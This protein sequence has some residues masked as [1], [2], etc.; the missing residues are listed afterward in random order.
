MDEEDLLLEKTVRLYKAKD[1]VNDYESCES[2]EWLQRN[3]AKTYMYT[4]TKHL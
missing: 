3:Y 2:E 1:R 4:A